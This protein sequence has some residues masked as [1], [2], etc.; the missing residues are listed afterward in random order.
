M[1]IQKE[2]IEKAERVGVSGKKE[3]INR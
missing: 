3:K 2:I 1:K